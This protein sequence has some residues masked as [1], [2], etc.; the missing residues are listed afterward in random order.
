MSY[1]IRGD[2]R[3]PCACRRSAPA[4]RCWSRLASFSNGPASSI[5]PAPRTGRAAGDAGVR[6]RA[7]VPAVIP[8]PLATTVALMRSLHSI[9]RAFRRIVLAL[10]CALAL[11][12]C[13]TWTEAPPPAPSARREISGPVRVVRPDGA[14]VVLHD[15]YVAGDTL[16]GF[17]SGTRM[18]VPLQSLQAIQRREVDSLPEPGRAGGGRGGDLLHVPARGHRLLRRRLSPAGDC[19]SPPRRPGH[20]GPT[21]SAMLRCVRG[22]V[23]VRRA[24]KIPTVLPTPLVTNGWLP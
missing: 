2:D 5:H 15:A 13:T 7:K 21:R 18:A 20:G 8:T 6:T 10:G 14:S 17:R 19:R 22:D 12:A 1:D 16:C 4:V 11:G 9:T 3:Q 24:R 23:R